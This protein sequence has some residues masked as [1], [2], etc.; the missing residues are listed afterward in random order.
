M[1]C[2]SHCCWISRVYID[3][4]EVTVVVLFWGPSP[5][6]HDSIH[7]FTSL[8][9]HARRAAAITS[10][11]WPA[12]HTCTCQVTRPRLSRPIA[13]SNELQLP[14]HPDTTFK[15]F[16]NHHGGCLTSLDSPSPILT[17]HRRPRNGSA[18][19]LA[20]DRTPLP[21]SAHA[22]T[23]QSEHQTTHFPTHYS[24]QSSQ[25][26]GSTARAPRR[27]LLASGTGQS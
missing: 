2:S 25:P 5:C 21:S 22:E 14:T 27:D 11:T 26:H 6:V 19:T 10:L 9:F 16:I 8:S 3:R 18:S 4:I 24:F 23:N 15:T 20:N 17:R 12:D 13:T 1:T 7:K